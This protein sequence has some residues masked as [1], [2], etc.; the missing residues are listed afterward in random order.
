MAS[1]QLTYYLMILKYVEILSNGVV[2]PVIEI[3][4]F[5]YV[6]WAAKNTT[7]EIFN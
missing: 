7:A 1:Q 4:S 2:K 5:N 6:S 3:I